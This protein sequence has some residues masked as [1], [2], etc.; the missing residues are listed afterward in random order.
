MTNMPL[1]LIQGGEVYTPRLSGRQDV[2]LCLGRILKI[3]DI[4]GRALKTTGLEVE[5]V[6][7]TGCIVTPGFIDPH[8]HL[9]GGSGEDGF[10]TQTPEISASEI[11]S[12]GITTVVGCL[13]VD[14]TMKTMPGLLAKAKALKEE[15]LNAYV[16]SGGY[17]TPPATINNS[18]STDIMFVDE[19]IGVGEIA[20]A[21]ERSTEPTPQELPGS[22]RK[23]ITAECLARNR[24]LRTS[25]WAIS[26]ID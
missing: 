16:W 3:G 20:I 18:I 1:T 4:D 23:R 26:P 15:G 9:L 14:T 25:M 24:G 12:A 21:D 10:A 22:F 7:A 8:E 13:G 19:I 11:V 6:D 5:S 17:R 2:L